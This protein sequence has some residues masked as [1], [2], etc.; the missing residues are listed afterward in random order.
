MSEEEI[1][2][3]ERARTLQLSRT[4]LLADLKTATNTHHRHMLEQALVAI[5]DQIQALGELP[6]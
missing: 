1:E 5:E 3:L 2:R 6:H 4:R